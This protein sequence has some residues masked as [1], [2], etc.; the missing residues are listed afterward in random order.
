MVRCGLT[1]G[2]NQLQTRQCDSMMRSSWKD[3]HVTTKDFVPPQ[4]YVVL[5]RVLLKLLHTTVAV[6]RSVSAY[7]S[8]SVWCGGVAPIGITLAVVFRQPAVLYALG[9]GGARLGLALAGIHCAVRH[10]NRVLLDRGA[11]YCANHSSNLEPSIVF[12]ALAGGSSET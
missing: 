11:V 1:G 2:R 5:V 12:M 10:A 4:P 9:R 8:V 7:V 6:A 3:S